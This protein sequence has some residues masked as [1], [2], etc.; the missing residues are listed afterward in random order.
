MTILYNIAANLKETIV[1]SNFDD[2][3]EHIRQ[4][5]PDNVIF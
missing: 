2:L 1:K 3:Q 4:K 5:I